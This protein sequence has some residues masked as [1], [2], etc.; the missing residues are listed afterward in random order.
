[1]HPNLSSC[2]KTIGNASGFYR[3]FLLDVLTDQ[4]RRGIPADKK[5]SAEVFFKSLYVKHANS[6]KLSD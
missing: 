1:M 5:K 6:A 4:A 3:I 2:R